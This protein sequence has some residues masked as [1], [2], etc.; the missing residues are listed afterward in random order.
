MKEIQ[1]QKQK[2]EEFITF[3]SQTPR[4]SAP[5]ELLWVDDVYKNWKLSEKAKIAYAK[6]LSFQDKG[7]LRWMNA[8]YPLPQEAIFIENFVIL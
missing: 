8:G 6:W 3:L 4:K 7:V 5:K 1:I 2:E